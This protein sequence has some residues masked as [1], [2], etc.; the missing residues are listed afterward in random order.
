MAAGAGAGRG[1]TGGGPPPSVSTPLC[2][3]ARDRR[4]RWSAVRGV[5]TSALP[6]I[7]SGNTNAPVIMVAERAADLIL[8]R[9]LLPAEDPAAAKPGAVRA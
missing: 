5:D 9:P 7:T 8:G 1:R 6:S 4:S 3:L 2:R